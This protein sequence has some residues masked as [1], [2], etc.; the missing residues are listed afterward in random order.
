M[1]TTYRALLTTLVAASSLVVLAAPSA[2][3]ITTLSS[4]PDMVSGGDVLVEIKAP[5][6]KVQVKLNGRDI[7]QTFHA[8]A[9]RG[10]L[11]GLVDGLRN[12]GNTI[13]A[14][15]GSHTATLQL[16][17]HPITGPIVSGEHLKPFVCNTEASGLGAPLDADCSAAT[18][19]EY[20]YHPT[21]TPDGTF[22]PLPDPH[23][24]R[25]ANLVH[26]TTSEGKT[27]P[28]IVR[29]ESGTINRAIYRIA[30][31]DDP[32]QNSPAHDSGWNRRI[33]YS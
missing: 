16:S 29:V 14:K 11:I 23:G 4:R 6:A 27:V 9:A 7:S 12:G 10:S 25:P 28:Y 8:D 3:T 19:I 33:F 20:F 17:N 24:P 1:S 26:T 21:E 32:S 22:K 30:I 13:V 2:L 18:K 15:A 31:L 5:T